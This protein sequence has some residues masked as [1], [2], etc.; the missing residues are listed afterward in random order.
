MYSGSMNK[1]LETQIIELMQ[2]IELDHPFLPTWD[3]RMSEL[4]DINPQLDKLIEE[5]QFLNGKKD[6]SP[7]T[8]A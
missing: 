1:K 2:K 7:D 6:Y 5:W 8:D 3:G 4:E